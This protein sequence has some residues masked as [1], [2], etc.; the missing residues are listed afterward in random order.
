MVAEQA[1]CYDE[2][3]FLFIKS[4]NESVYCDSKFVMNGILGFL[5]G[6]IT[7]SLSLTQIKMSIM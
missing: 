1:L 7:I 5:E 2:Y 3:N 4:S 6:K